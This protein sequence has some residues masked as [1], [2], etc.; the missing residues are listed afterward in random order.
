MRVRWH[1]SVAALAASGLVA[2]A[3]PNPA[4]P[5][6]EMTAEAWR[7]DLRFLASELPKRHASLFARMDE[8]LFKRAVADLDARIPSLPSHEMAVGLARIVA[9]AGDGH[10]ELFLRQEATGFRR[11][12]LG[13]HYFG[14]DLYVLY[15]SPE[16]REAVGRKV[17]RIGLTPSRAAY[18]KVEPLLARD[19]EMELIYAAP[20]YLVVAEVLHALGVIPD[21]ES[22]SYTLEGDGGRPM[23]VR[24]GAI[25]ESLASGIEWIGA[26][27]AAGSPTP[28]HARHP[29]REHWYEWLEKER[30]LYVKYDRCEDQE[31]QPSIGSFS[32]EMFRL[33]DSHPVERLVIDLRQ[34]PGGNFHKNAP[35]IEGILKRSGVNA[36]G[37]L[38]ALIGRRTFSAATWMALVLKQK[39]NAILVGEPSRGRPNGSFNYEWMH[40]PNSRLKVDYTDKLHTPAPELGD[41]PTLPI[42]LRVET[43][44]DDYLAGR[45][46]VL[47]AALTYRAGSNPR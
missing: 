9:M 29:E 12:P 7:E 1:R 22:A 45:D 37:R 27:E 43:T 44:F 16:H 10:T 13:L 25:S 26:R 20:H 18:E 34:N 33:L 14:P 23:E 3:T 32:K 46:P 17:I 42:D 38:F 11:F 15:A 40:L 6:K 4:G 2:T 41:T 8:E 28:L 36:K 35:L 21:M 19:N 24:F 30:T 47:E 39:T 5:L 31:G